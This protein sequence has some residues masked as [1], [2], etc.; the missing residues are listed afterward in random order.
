MASITASA[1]TPDVA[2]AIWSSATTCQRTLPL[3]STAT[4]KYG[5]FMNWIDLDLS[6][7]AEAAQEHDRRAAARL[8]RDELAQL[9]DQLIC[10]HYR[11]QHVIR[12]AVDEVRRLQVQL[13]LTQARPSKRGPSACHIGWARD[14]LSRLRGSG[15]L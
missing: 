8:H 13:A 6:L 10:A 9:V 4:V 15:S 1:R 2:Q 14:L 11:H 12:Q 5:S 3:G 7:S